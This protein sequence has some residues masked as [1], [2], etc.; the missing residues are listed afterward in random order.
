MSKSDTGLQNSYK[1]LENYC[2]TNKSTINKSGRLLRKRFNINGINIENVRTYKYL[3]FLLTPSGE[4]NSGL[5]Y[6]SDRAMK[7]F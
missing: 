4:V 1:V 5:K 3:G 6:L 7:G 2:K